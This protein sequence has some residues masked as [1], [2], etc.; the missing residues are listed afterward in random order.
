MQSAA[1]SEGKKTLTLRTASKLQIRKPQ[2]KFRSLL[3]VA[4]T[5]LFTMYYCA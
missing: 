1:R 5:N 2:Y 3:L 4:L